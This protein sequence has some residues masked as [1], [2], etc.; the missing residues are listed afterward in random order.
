MTAKP[1]KYLMIKRF[2]LFYH[3]AFE[4][5]WTI[6]IYSGVFVSYLCLMYESGQYIFTNSKV[7]NA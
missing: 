4:N 5:E 3:I 6:V 7:L 2:K 1:Q